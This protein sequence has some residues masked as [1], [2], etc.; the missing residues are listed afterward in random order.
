MTDSQ[1]QFLQD[2]IK[3]YADNMAADIAAVRLADI[4]RA[5]LDQVY[6][7]WAGATKPGVGHYYRIQGPS[8]SL[9]L[10]NFQSDPANNPANHIHSV[11]RSLEHDFGV[12]AN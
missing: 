11:W 8:F 3:V 6:F 7:A 4:D 9:E 5:G 12:V 10:V 1:K 2:L